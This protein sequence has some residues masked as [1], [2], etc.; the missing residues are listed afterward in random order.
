M[1]INH[2]Q[3]IENPRPTRKKAK[4][5]SKLIPN[6]DSVEFGSNENHLHGH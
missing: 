5:Y 1:K 2:R 4:I 3:V 6:G